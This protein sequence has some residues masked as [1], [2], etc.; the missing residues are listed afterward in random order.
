MPTNREATLKVARGLLYTELGE[1]VKPSVETVGNLILTQ[2]REAKL[3]AL[4]W[5]LKSC[6]ND[7]GLQYTS[8]VIQ[9]GI[10]AEIALLEGNKASLDEAGEEINT[11]A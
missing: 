1:Y 8:S 11:N 9:V 10:E 3:E 7:H 5:A 4:K 2:R 6:T